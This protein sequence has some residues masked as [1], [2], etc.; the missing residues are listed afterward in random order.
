MS[1]EVSD[2]V[3]LPD[4]DEMMLSVTSEAGGARI[5]FAVE[6]GLD[7]RV[8]YSDTLLPGTWLPLTGAPHNTG[9]LLDA[10]AVGV[11][12]RFYR[13]VVERQ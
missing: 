7:Y 11:P 8:E 6:A 1:I 2:P 13:L 10:T 12:R 4:P 9:D 3:M 5:Q